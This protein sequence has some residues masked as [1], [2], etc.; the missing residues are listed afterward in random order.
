MSHEYD[1]FG[2]I[3][4]S[5][6]KITEEQIASLNPIK[7]KGYYYDAEI[8]MYRL[9]TRFYDPEIGRFL[10]AD[11]LSLLQETPSSLGDKN[12][13]AYCDNNPVTRKDSNGELWWVATAAIGAAIN[14]G[15]EIASQL[16]ADGEVTDWKAVGVNAAIGAV[17][18]VIPGGKAIETLGGAICGGVSSAY[19]NYK[20][21]GRRSDAFMAGI[22][23]AGFSLVGGSASDKILKGAKL[24]S[25]KYSIFSSK[26]TKV[27]KNYKSKL[28]QGWNKYKNKYRGISGRRQF[29]QSFFSNSFLSGLKL[30][31]SGIRANR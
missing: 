8:A 11:D 7:Y 28:G 30:T 19:N 4:T 26:K 29:Y 5:S 1:A 18:G 17:S 23:G 15:L 31:Y 22:V 3:Y 2:K 10:N 9:E 14:A 25:P 13:Y 20:L 6:N 16:I 21:T 24:S 27:D 12:L